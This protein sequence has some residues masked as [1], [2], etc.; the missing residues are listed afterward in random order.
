LEKKAKQDREAFASKLQQNLCSSAEVRTIEPLGNQ[1]SKS[2]TKPS[3]KSLSGSKTAT[4]DGMAHTNVYQTLNSGL[5]K[6]F[7]VEQHYDEKRGIKHQ[8]IK[9]NSS[10]SQ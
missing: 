3:Q 2:K 9:A 5:E 10:S 4:A 7:S 1:S 6:S 8:P